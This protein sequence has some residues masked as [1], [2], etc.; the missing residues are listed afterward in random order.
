M[1]RK[2]LTKAQ[3]EKALNVYAEPYAG[4]AL[5]LYRED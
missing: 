1:A 5:C 4:Y 3:Q 2:T